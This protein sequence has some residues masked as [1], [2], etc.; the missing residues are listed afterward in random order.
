MIIKIKKSQILSRLWLTACFVCVL[1][2]V[3]SSLNPVI[4]TVLL[5]PL[6]VYSAWRF[7]HMKHAAVRFPVTALRLNK[8][9]QCTLESGQHE[10]H[11]EVQN[12]WCIGNWCLLHLGDLSHYANQKLILAPDILTEQERRYLRRWLKGYED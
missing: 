4:Q 5:V 9:K 6:F 12:F 1:P 3:L 8:D 10:Y 2:I 11:A 7:G